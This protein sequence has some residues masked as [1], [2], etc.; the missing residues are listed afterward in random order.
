MS[1]PTEVGRRRRLAE[2]NA[3]PGTREAL[4]A[5]HGAVWDTAQ[6]TEE[7]DCVG[8]HAPYVVVRRKADGV[9]GSLEFQHEP[10]FYFN[11]APH[12]AMQAAERTSPKETA[13][14]GLGKDYERNYQLLT[15]LLGDRDHVRIENKPYLP[16]AV[17]R[18]WEGYFTLCHYGELNGDPMRD[19]EV[20]FLVEGNSARPAY[21]RNDYA[22]FHQATVPGCFG[23]ALVKE[24]G[25]KDLDQFVSEWW[26]NIREQG[27]F[28]ASR[29]QVRTRRHER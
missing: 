3:E 25:Q 28:E 29:E 22:A 23:D 17:E 7:F 11:F 13:V 20:I 5:R 8:F 16:L 6:L 24:A 21:F 27:F 4:A 2:I 9:L 19:P 14:V 26:T 10:R 12:D 1:D 15:E 18:L